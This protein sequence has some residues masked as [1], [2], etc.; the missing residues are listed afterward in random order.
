MKKMEAHI[1]KA[2]GI[3]VPGEKVRLRSAYVDDPGWFDY[4][5]MGTLEETKEDRDL[6]LLTYTGTVVGAGDHPSQVLVRLESEA[7][8]RRRKA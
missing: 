7:D 3:A 4:V 6:F 1:V 5:I 2:A 8:N